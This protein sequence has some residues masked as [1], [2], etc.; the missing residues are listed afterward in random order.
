MA[1]LCGMPITNRPLRNFA[2][3]DTVN[4]A[5]FVGQEGKGN[6]CSNL[7]KVSLSQDNAMSGAW[8]KLRELAAKEQD[9]AKLRELVVEI[10]C[11]LNVI[12]IQLA[13]VEGGGKPTSH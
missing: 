7:V 5:A 8:C 13:K 2:H 4:T 12:E 9:T 10:N 11:L 1:L 3:H 6:K